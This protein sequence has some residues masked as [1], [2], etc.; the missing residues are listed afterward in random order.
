[1]AVSRVLFVSG[2]S[3]DPNGPSDSWTY[4]GV[5]PD[6]FAGTVATVRGSFRRDQWKFDDEHRVGV[7]FDMPVPGAMQT[8]SEGR[9]DWRGGFFAPTELELLEPATTPT[10]SDDDDDG[11][12]QG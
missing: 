9:R 3:H 8:H 4:P 6:G 7:L 1:M 11:E 10:T 2:H 5:T 12:G